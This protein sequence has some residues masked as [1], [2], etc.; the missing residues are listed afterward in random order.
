MVEVTHTDV[1]IMTFGNY[2]SSMRGLCLIVV[3]S[4][5]VGL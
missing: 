1:R 3:K 4:I 5:P 2:S